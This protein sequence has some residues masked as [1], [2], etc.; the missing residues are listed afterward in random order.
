MN[1]KPES[2]CSIANEPKQATSRLTTEQIE[3]AKIFLID[4]EPILLE[5]YEVYLSAVGF[6]QISSFTDSVE[7]VETL[8]YITPSIILTDI[9]MPEVSGNFLIKLIRTYEHLRTVPIVAVTSNTDTES[10][11][12][13][14][15]K[16][17]DSVMHKPVDAKS[18]TD[19][20]FQTLES[21]LKLKNQ[22]SVAQARENQKSEQK[23]AQMMT[24]ESDLRHMMRY[25]DDTPV[26]S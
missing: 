21:T 15:R 6:K 14:M 17:A 22:L 5:L 13:I 11:E 26:D 10:Q 8:R 1:A 24:V 19:R 3:A 9:V 25:S 2:N 7:A 23:K 4:D 18:L 20:V 12:T 16:G